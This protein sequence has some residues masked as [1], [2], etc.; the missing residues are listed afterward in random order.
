VVYDPAPARGCS[1]E[2]YGEAPNLRT[3]RDRL[4]LMPRVRGHGVRPRA[5]LALTAAPGLFGAAAL[6]GMAITFA[7]LVSTPAVDT[8]Q[9]RSV[10]HDA[11]SLYLGRG[12]Y[13]DPAG[14]GYTGLLY[15]PLEPMM[16]ALVDEVGVW[17]GWPVIVTIGATLGLALLVAWLAYSHTEDR[18]LWTLA[19]AVGMG[20]AAVWLVTSAA[21]VLY[22][23]WS[24]E[25]AWAFALGGLVTGARAQTS[26]SAAALT[27]TLLTLAFWSKQTTVAASIAYAAWLI[28][29]TVRRERTARFTVSLLLALLTANLAVLGILNLAT[30][31]W[32][33]YFNFLLPTHQARV[34][35]VHQFASDLL[36][37]IS[38][39]ALWALALCLA[40][41]RSNRWRL[42]GRLDSVCALLALFVVVG[43]PFAMYF[44]SKQGGEQN[45]YFG[46]IWALGAIAALAWGNSRRA[47]RPGAADCVVV[48]GLLAAVFA[49]GFRA[50]RFDLRL[51]RLDYTY[52]IPTDLRA[53][54]HRGTLF[55]PFY[56]DLVP[57]AVYPDVPNVSD[58]LA[59]GEQPMGLVNALLDRR[60]EYVVTYAS[61]LGP[62]MAYSNTYA[63]GYG[64]HEEN[65]F[66]KLD[67]VIAAGY[68]T[69]P[70]LPPGA[71]ERRAGSNRAAALASCFAPF[72][73]A[74]QTWTIRRGGGFW[75]QTS[76]DVMA[77]GAVPVS[78]SELITDKALRASGSLRLTGR[79]GADV[80]IT[81]G[82][83]WAV[84][85]SR[86]SAGWRVISGRAGGRRSAA[87]SSST[88]L[89]LAFGR[90]P[91]LAVSP[92]PASARVSILASSDK[93]VRIDMTDLRL[94]S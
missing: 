52:S 27:V 33:W 4:L 41:F 78:T 80:L 35:G 24:D 67:R 3:E 28:V 51:L 44:R 16:I 6:V 5:A 46:V 79:P 82:D 55:D 83:G 18:T 85:A 29:L 20:G 88:A 47:A 17:N 75:C 81:G 12:I 94:Q 9:F 45:Q 14:N 54:A 53:L 93:S 36:R 91:G 8:G 7:T 39:P 1:R 59:S 57:G 49:T 64:A 22:L 50:Q 13:H 77:L 92:D 73:D 26:R 70:G 56:T 76:P 86:D 21:G 65:Y 61:A 15:T 74:G 2:R 10:G 37:V 89:T 90:G 63:A 48:L 68:R 72:D 11:L 32:E 84:N 23:G 71:L 40:A 87:T 34:Y 62:G 31:G 66:W 58:L 43:L 42:R 25:L 19:G 38:V 60:F 69:A 30:H